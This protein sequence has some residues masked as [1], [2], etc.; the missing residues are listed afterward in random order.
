MN[1]ALVCFKRLGLKPSIYYN[2]INKQITNIS[3]TVTLKVPP[4]LKL[5][6][7]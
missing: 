2:H 1:I 5:M 7:T 6:E 3:A 4:A